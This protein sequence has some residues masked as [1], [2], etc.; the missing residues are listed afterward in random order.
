MSVQESS[1]VIVKEFAPDVAGEYVGWVSVEPRESEE[2]S[3]SPEAIF[4]VDLAVALVCRN[5]AKLT[6]TERDNRKLQG[7]DSIAG[8]SGAVAIHGIVQEGEL[9]DDFSALSIYT[10]R[11][12]AE[13]GRS[14]Q[15]PISPNTVINTGAALR[16]SA[17]Y[18]ARTWSD[19]ME[20]DGIRHP[21]LGALKDK[22][23]AV[24]ANDTAYPTLYYLLNQFMVHDDLRPNDLYD[25]YDKPKPLY[26]RV[27]VDTDMHQ[28][29]LQQRDAARRLFSALSEQFA[30][31]TR[32]DLDVLPDELP[33]KDRQAAAHEFEISRQRAHELESE[34]IENYKRLLVGQTVFMPTGFRPQGRSWPY[35]DATC[36]DERAAFG[37]ELDAIRSGFTGSAHYQLAAEASELGKRMLYAHNGWQALRILSNAEREAQ[38]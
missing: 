24:G 27:L 33:E 28:E 30:A 11:Y 15:G 16:R 22:L 18:E 2:N 12:E 13:W 5:G 6:Y 26:E 8:F 25:E 38:S 32:L 35:M 3:E 31:N 7:R 14:Y 36:P 10:S 9:R 34:A 37:R 23:S 29:T 20:D 19:A 17:P 4:D 21:L 1:E